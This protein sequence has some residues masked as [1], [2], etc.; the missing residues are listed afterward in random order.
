MSWYML[1]ELSASKMNSGW[2][3]PGKPEALEY[4]E[5]L[6]YKFLQV[7]SQIHRYYK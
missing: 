1:R 3:L 4:I 5:N 7:N 6:D 2:P